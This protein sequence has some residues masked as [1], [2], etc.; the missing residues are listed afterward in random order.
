MEIMKKVTGIF[1]HKGKMT[2]EELKEHLLFLK[3]LKE[4][5]KGDQV[6]LKEILAAI[7]FTKREIKR[8][9]NYYSVP[10]DADE[11]ELGVLLNQLLQEKRSPYWYTSKELLAN[12][13]SDC[14]NALVVKG[15]NPKKWIA[16]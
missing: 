2:Y 9:E 12:A 10:L 15:C 16:A 13:I 8:Y 7:S 5:S 1:P 6:M 14:M 4:R 3:A 11:T